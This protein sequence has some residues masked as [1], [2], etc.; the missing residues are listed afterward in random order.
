MPE[1]QVLTIVRHGADV[2]PQMRDEFLA[3]HVD[4]RAALLEQP[5]YSAERFWER[6]ENYVKDPSFHMVTGRLGGILVGYAFGSTLPSETAWWSGIQGVSDPDLTRE[7]GRRTF[8]FRELLVRKP[9]QRKGYAHQLH[10][11]LLADRPEERA[12]LLVRSDNSARDLYLR[13]GWS[14]VG[15]LQPYP[16]SPR[17]EAMIKELGSTS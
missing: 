10:D 9:N 15:H 2:V 3:V 7:T 11:S 8:A 6:F 4:A 12:T 13:W 16:D 14:L 5:F 1:Q 17:F